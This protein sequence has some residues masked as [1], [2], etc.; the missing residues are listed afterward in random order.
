MNL[1][2]YFIDIESFI[3]WTYKNPQLF[4]K[5]EINQKLKRESHCFF[6]QLLKC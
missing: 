1:D 5:N 3:K 2:N 6:V 4:Y